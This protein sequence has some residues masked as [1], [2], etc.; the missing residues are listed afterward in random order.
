MTPTPA[1]RALSGVA[2]LW[3]LSCASSSAPPADSTDSEPH[4][5]RVVAELEQD[6]ARSRA[7]DAVPDSVRA[8]LLPDFEPEP[9]ARHRDGGTRFDLAVSNVPTREFFLGLVQD[10]D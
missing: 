7:A 8:E 4:P 5:A 2:A 6:A 1:R 3:L 10:S 9:L